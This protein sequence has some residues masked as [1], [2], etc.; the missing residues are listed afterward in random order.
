MKPLYET[1]GE[2]SRLWEKDGCRGDGLVGIFPC[3]LAHDLL[4]KD[5][6]NVL[7]VH[8]I[9]LFQLMNGLLFVLFLNLF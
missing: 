2:H 4:A 3:G 6:G 5:K 9:D 8:H 1:Q 7:L